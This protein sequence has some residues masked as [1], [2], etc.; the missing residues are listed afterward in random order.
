MPSNRE[1]IHLSHPSLCEWLFP[2]LNSPLASFDPSSSC[3]QKWWLQQWP[4]PQGGQT[5]TLKLWPWIRSRGRALGGP[6]PCWSFALSQNVFNIHS[7]HSYMQQHWEIGLVGVP[8]VQRIHVLKPQW[9]SR[10]IASPKVCDVYIHTHVYAYII[11]HIYC[12][13]HICMR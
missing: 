12:K 6:G 7:S 1:K 5:S 10:T 4:L 8:S 3:K 13:H 11:Y 2:T 9:M